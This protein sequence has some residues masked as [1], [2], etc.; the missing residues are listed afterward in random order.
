MERDRERRLV[1][2]ANLLSLPDCSGF[3]K[4]DSEE[5]ARLL[6]PRLEMDEDEEVSPPRLDLLWSLLL[7]LLELDDDD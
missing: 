4:D 3:G 6:L 1:Y 2:L 5:E 7:P